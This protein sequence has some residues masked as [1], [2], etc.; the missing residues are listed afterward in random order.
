MNSITFTIDKEEVERISGRKLESGES[1]KILS[2]IE[3]DTVLW[4]N[5]EESI[6]SASAEF[7]KSNGV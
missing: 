6:A 7:F 1:E 2:M 5:I 4:D 3:N